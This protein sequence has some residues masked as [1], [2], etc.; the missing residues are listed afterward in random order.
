MCSKEEKGEVDLSSAQGVNT[1]LFMSPRG[2][3]INTH[4]QP[5]TNYFLRL[6]W[7]QEAWNGYEMILSV[8]GAIS[9]VIEACWS[10]KGTPRGAPV[11]SKQGSEGSS[12]LLV[13]T[14]LDPSGKERLK[15]GVD[16]CGGHK[17]SGG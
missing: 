2:K 8:M 15:V 10:G 3:S 4:F 6:P 14:Q 16:V 7:S 11:S 17:Q 5:S 12:R 13:G 9:V 1:A